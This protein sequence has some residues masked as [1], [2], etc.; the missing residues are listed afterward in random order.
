MSLKWMNYRCPVFTVFSVPWSRQCPHCLGRCLGHGSSAREYPVS[1]PPLQLLQPSTTDGDTHPFP[2]H[3]SEAVS[4]RSQS[5]RESCLRTCSPVPHRRRLATSSHWQRAEKASS[6]GPVE[7]RHA[8]HGG[9]ALTTARPH[10][11]HLP[12]ASPPLTIT[13]GAGFPH[14]A[15][16]GETRTSDQNSVHVQGALS[17]NPKSHKMHRGPKSCTGGGAS[18]PEV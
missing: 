16:E 8:S 15:L 18:C 1:K 7:G 14:M 11:G 12:K 5:G 17:A 13:L 2:S 10:F 6:P 4:P 9:S 3:S